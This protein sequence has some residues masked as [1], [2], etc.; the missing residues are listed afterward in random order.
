VKTFSLGCTSFGGAAPRLCFGA[1]AFVFARSS[2]FVISYLLLFHFV[3][4]LVFYLFKFF[5]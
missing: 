1:A 5:G 3:L 4:L 2:R